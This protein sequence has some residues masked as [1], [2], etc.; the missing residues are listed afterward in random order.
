MALVLPHV[1]VMLHDFKLTDRAKHRALTGADNRRIFENYQ[2]A[3]LALRG[4]HMGVARGSW[5]LRGLDKT[6]INQ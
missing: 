3:D 5:R 4:Q 1:A 6:T 2:R